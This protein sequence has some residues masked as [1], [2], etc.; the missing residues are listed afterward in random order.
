APL[1][2]TAARRAGPAISA[3]RLD[4]AHLMVRPAV[5]AAP[6]GGSS[7]DPGGGAASCPGGTVVLRRPGNQRAVEP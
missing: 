3:S 7:G 1:L 5:G 6:G 2:A 4:L